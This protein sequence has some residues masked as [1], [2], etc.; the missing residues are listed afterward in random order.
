MRRDTSPPNPA[1]QAPK[2]AR[3][4]QKENL[5]ARSLIASRKLQFKENRLQNDLTVFEREKADARVAS[6]SG[7]IWGV[8]FCSCPTPYLENILNGVSNFLFLNFVHLDKSISLLCRV[9]F[10]IHPQKINLESR[11]RL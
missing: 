9:E 11:R 5:D 6:F 3:I 8:E 10:S 2:I 1:P 4:E 7:T